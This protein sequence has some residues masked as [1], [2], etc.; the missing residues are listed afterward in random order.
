[1]SSSGANARANATGPNRP[2]YIR[3]MKSTLDAK[4]VSGIMPVDAP[5]VPNADT[6][7]KMTSKNS[8]SGSRV[9]NIVAVINMNA[10]PRLATQRVLCT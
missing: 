9:V 8:S 1:M 4:P 5:V 10:M 3:T 6:V 7:S 2:T